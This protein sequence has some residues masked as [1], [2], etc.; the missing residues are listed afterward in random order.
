MTNSQ[1]VAVAMSGDLR[2]MNTPK[3]QTA[4]PDTKYAKSRLSRLPGLRA[5][6]IPTSRTF[7]TSAKSGKRLWSVKRVPLGIGER[8]IGFVLPAL[9]VDLLFEDAED[10]DVPVPAVLVAGLAED[11]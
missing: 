10:E 4:K 9:L 3:F 5:S 6:V 1:N 2:S 8:E 11:A 7:R